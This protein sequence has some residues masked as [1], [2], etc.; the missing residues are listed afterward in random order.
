MRGKSFLRRQVEWKVDS[1][2]CA[3]RNY[4]G[5][6]GWIQLYRD[7]RVLTDELYARLPIPKLAIENSAGAWARD[8][9]QVLAFLGF[10]TAT[11]LEAQS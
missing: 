3:Q 7:Y 4:E 5:V 11:N 1:P 10:P 8:E 2:Y 9:Q 6:P